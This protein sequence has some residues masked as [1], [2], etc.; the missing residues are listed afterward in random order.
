MLLDMGITYLGEDTFQ[1]LN[2][3]NYLD[4]A[5]NKIKCLP[6]EIFQNLANL[7]EL[8]LDD[9]PL[10]CSSTDYILPGKLSQVGQPTCV[11]YDTDPCQ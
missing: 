9:N 6:K 11:N 3:L 8:W 5:Y 1:G 4:L 7:E 10:S 2:E